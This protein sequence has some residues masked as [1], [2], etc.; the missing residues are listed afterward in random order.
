M[1]SSKPKYNLSKIKKLL[2]DSDSYHITLEAHRGAAELGYM[3][4]ESIIDVI[5]N[6]QEDDFLS[7]CLQKR[8]KNYGK[9]FIE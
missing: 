1:S 8:C 3:D 5:E 4:A 7:P 9:M 6:I 2:C